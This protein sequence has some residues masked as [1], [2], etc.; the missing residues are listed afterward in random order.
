VKKVTN[1]RIHYDLTEDFRYQQGLKVGKE[2]GKAEAKV[3][4]LVLGMRIIKLYQKGKTNQE[5]AEALQIDLSTVAL[6]LK[7]YNE[8]N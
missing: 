1:M 5:I 8:T 3:E 7:A 6:A 4:R 2:I